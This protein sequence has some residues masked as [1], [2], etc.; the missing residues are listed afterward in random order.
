MDDIAS[1]STE[2][3]CDFEKELLTTTINHTL[4]LI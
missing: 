4:R 1:H 3:D 2:E